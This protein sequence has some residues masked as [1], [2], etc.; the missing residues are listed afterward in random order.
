MAS[1]FDLREE[2]EALQDLS[3]YDIPNEQDFLSM[4]TGQ[5]GGLLERTVDS[6]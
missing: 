3:T 6:F 5:V 4:S 2:T 1:S